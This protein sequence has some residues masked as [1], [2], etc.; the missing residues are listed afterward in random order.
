MKTFTLSGMVTISVHTKV[1]AET[2]KDAIEI[3]GQRGI[4]RYEW[5]Q[6]WIESEAWISSEYDGEV[7]DIKEN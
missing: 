5:G 1:K 2:L 4:E 6:D 7:F 3:A